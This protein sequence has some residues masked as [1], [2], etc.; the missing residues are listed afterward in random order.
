MKI[1][2]LG[3]RLF[4]GDKRAERQT[5]TTKLFCSF[6]NAPKIPSIHKHTKIS[7]GQCK[8]TWILWYKL[9]CNGKATRFF[10]SVRQGRRCVH[11]EQFSIP[12]FLSLIVSKV[13]ITMHVVLKVSVCK[14]E[15]FQRTWTF[16]SRQRTVI[17]AG[18]AV[19][20]QECIIGANCSYIR[21]YHVKEEVIYFLKWNAIG[22]HIQLRK[23][24]CGHRGQWEMIFF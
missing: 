13:Q 4:H 14:P 18:M 20:R 2:T 19:N 1:L 8:T 23:L 22:L 5:D 7:L 16:Q 9:R 11:L 15:C 12:L 24:E 6:A 21:K 17:E 3:A 10:S